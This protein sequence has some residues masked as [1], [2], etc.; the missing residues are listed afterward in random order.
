MKVLQLCNKVP[1]PPR[2]GGCIAMNNLTQGLLQQGCSV[3]VLA[4]NPEKLFVDINTLPEAYRKNTGIEAVVI[5]TKVKPIPALFNLI[6]SGSYNIS[7]FYSKAFEEKLIEVLKKENFDVVHLESIYVSMYMDTIRKYSKAKVVLRAHNV[8]YR[9]WER[10]AAA[11]RKARL[12]WYYNFLSKRLKQ[13]E[14]VMLDQYD[15]VAA[16]TKQDAAW[17]KENKFKGTIKV[18]PF[19]I[20]L[21]SFKVEA[22]AQKERNS[23]FHIGAM[24][25]Q[26][27]IEGV[28]WLL[29]E[30][31]DKVSQNHPTAK[32]YLAGRKMSDELKNLKQ[33]NVVVEGEVNDAYQFMLSKGLMV[34]PLLAGGGMRVKIIEGMS[35]GKT[36]ITTSVGAEGIDC[37]S[38]VNIILADTAEAFADAITKYIQDSE[39]FEQIGKNAQ[40]F[41]AQHYNNADICR[42]LIEFYKAL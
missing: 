17:F 5:D 14:I 12:K 15:A 20:D 37:E 42:K 1:F 2:D 40:S 23:V 33:Q 22:P 16:I 6:G 41:A 4:I 24:D 34:V 28:N 3:K 39:R 18:V 7:R 27:N 9:I 19:G 36:I 32:L 26:P 13:Y 30:I 8:E 29:N 11:S 31:W 35:L 21:N 25:W 10:N 38:G